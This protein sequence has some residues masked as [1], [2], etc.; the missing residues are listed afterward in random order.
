MNGAESDRKAPSPAAF[1]GDTGNRCR[2]R[3]ANSAGET[4]SGNSVNELSKNGAVRYDDTRT[5]AVDFVL[6]TSPNSS[7]FLRKEEGGR[8][9]HPDGQRRAQPRFFA[10]RTTADWAPAC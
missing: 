10:R 2:S 4:S 9:S 6:R 3:P 5:H 8:R 1:A 7:F